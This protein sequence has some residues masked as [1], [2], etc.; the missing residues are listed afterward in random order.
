MAMQVTNTNVV[1]YNT[2]TG[3]HEY[4]HGQTWDEFDGPQ[5]LGS[6]MNRDGVKIPVH[7]IVRQGEWGCYLPPHLAISPSPIHRLAL[8]GHLDA[9]IALSTDFL[10]ALEIA[11]RAAKRAYH[12]DNIRRAEKAQ[13]EWDNVR[14]AEKARHNTMIQHGHYLVVLASSKHIFATKS[15]ALAFAAEAD[16]LSISQGNYSLRATGGIVVKGR[17]FR[18]S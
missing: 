10:N 18:L 11:D 13:R 6:F 1:V 2:R 5:Y 4:A 8:L 14:R 3:H 9:K 17:E 12:A 15:E 16:A 7:P